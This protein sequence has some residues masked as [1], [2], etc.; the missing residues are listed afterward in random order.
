MAWKC[1]SCEQVTTAGEVMKTIAWVA[2]LGV[3]GYVAFTYKDT[4]KESVNAAVRK[5][6]SVSGVPKRKRLTKAA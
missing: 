6:R 3:V 4:I 2:A 5:T 1:E